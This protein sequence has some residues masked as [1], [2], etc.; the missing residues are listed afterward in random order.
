M[1]SI[2]YLFPLWTCFHLSL[3]PHDFYNTCIAIVVFG[4]IT[5]YPLCK[6]MQYDKAH[7]LVREIKKKVLKLP[8]NFCFFLFL[9]K[10]S[11]NKFC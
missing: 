2:N 9:P 4:L 3:F 1:D 5:Q 8:P 7:G 10:I 11:I 6:G